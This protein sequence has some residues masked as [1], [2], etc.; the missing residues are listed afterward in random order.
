MIGEHPFRSG[1]TCE[2]LP[3]TNAIDCSTDRRLTS[4][5][6]NLTLLNLVPK[7]T[8]NQTINICNPILLWQYSFLHATKVAFQVADLTCVP[9]CPASP[10]PA[11]PN[12]RVWPVWLIMEP[13]SWSLWTTW[14]SSIFGLPLTLLSLSITLVCRRHFSKA[15]LPIHSFHVTSHP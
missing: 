13:L 1:F 7:L 10:N 12:P 8:L 15:N 5:I 3:C 4:L 11:S 9:W 2:Q 14:R 6:P